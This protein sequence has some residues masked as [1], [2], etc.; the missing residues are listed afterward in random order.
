[1]RVLVTGAASGLGA[2]LANAFEQRGDEVVRTDVDTLDVTSDADW[3][4][5]R[6]QVERLDLLVNNAG[7]ATGGRIDVAGMDEWHRAIEVNLLGAVRGCRTFV[8]VFK[9]QGSG[10]ILNIASLA[11]LVHPPAMASYTT[12]KAGVV[13]LSETLRHELHAWNIRVAVACP[14]FFQTNLAASVDSADPVTAALTARLIG[15]SSLTA[16]DVARAII[17]GFDA[18][19]DVI[20]PDPESQVAVAAKRDHYE[21]YREQQYA[22]ARR[23]EGFDKTTDPGQM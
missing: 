11:G 5:M 8:P 21:A 13:A 6:S 15:R 3:E 19:Q 4:R 14:G 22:F 10:A 12:T 9:E 7:I 1:M 17:E 18:G 16:D 2:A 20:L 23:I